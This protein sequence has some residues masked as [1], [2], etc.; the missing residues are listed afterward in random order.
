M[1]VIEA[2]TPRFSD[3]LVLA[4]RQKGLS[5]I[6]LAAELSVAPSTVSRWEA[7]RVVPDVAMLYRIA[8]VTEAEWLLDLRSRPL[9]WMNETPGQ[10]LELAVAV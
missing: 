1:A 9:P 8:A 4:R 3:R 5:Q 2:P 7:G 10:S 6:S